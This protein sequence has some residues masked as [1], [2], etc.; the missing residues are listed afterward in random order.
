MHRLLDVD[1]R[2][3][4]IFRAITESRGM[5]GAELVL[6]MSQSR[7]SASLAELE[8]RLGVRLCWRGRSGFSL[9][10]AGEAVYEASSEL[11]EA[12][13]RFSNSA[14]AVSANVRRVLRIGAVDAVVTN[15][16]LPLSDAFMK[17]RQQMPMVTVDFS[18]AGPE[19]LEKQLVSGSRD[20]I[21]VPGHT[22]RPEFTYVPLHAEK[23]S[24]YC[25]AGHPLA[26]MD[27]RAGAA[28]LARH[29]FV[30]RGY[31]HSSDLKRI[32]HRHA[33]ATVETME[34]QLILILSGAFV[35]YLPAHY[36]QEWV[37]SGKLKVLWDRKLSYDSPF[38]AVGL[39]A[40]TANPIARRFVSILVD[41]RAKLNGGAKPSVTA[42]EHA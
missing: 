18:T 30:A 16:E 11:F 3:I 33:E 37:R 14:G 15:R 26:R 21:V 31:L 42:L 29:A 19:D 32:G 36:A 41:E 22:R 20:L 23:Q 8:T 34:A 25:A 9:T 17:L 10:E 24:L 1:L 40:R 5:A 4:R 12:V 13:A 28:A 39:A 2:L 35:G 38:F 6:N 27:A 7:I